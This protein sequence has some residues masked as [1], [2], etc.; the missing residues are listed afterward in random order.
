MLVGNHGLSCVLFSL[1][2]GEYKRAH[3]VKL[4]TDAL[5]ETELA[6]THQSWELVVELKKSKLTTKQQSESQ[7]VRPCSEMLLRLYAA[8]SYILYTATIAPSRPMPRAGPE[9]QLAAAAA[10]NMS[11]LHARPVG[12]RRRV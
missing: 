11:P 5:Y 6:A 4:S 2:Q 12:T 1:W 9:K 3:E 8:D 10:A 7:Q